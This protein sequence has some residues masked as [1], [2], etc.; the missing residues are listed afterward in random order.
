MKKICCNKKC[1][2]F[3]PQLVENFNK[4][5]NTKDGLQKHCKFCRLTFR[6]LNKEKIKVQQS[7]WQKNNPDKVRERNDRWANKNRDKVNA[8]HRRWRNKNQDK[9]RTAKREWAKKNPN[10]I[11]A[12]KK[13]S[14]E[15]NKD[16]IKVQQSNWQKNNPDKVRER[17]KKWAKKNPGRVSSIVAKRRAK[18]LS[19]TP[20]WLTEEQKIEIQEFY[21]LA[22]ELQWLSEE[23]LQVDHI[24]PM[25]GKNVSG[26]HVPWN[27]QIL[28]RSMNSSKNNKF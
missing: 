28:T 21:I 18:K 6:N 13:R 19:A 22:K 20:P 25:Q 2:Q 1:Q 10:K 15:K 27:L 7:N 26:L 9:M 14:Y 12:Q 16:K 24:I 8:K 11:K 17:N 23:P 5:K 4:N 3:N